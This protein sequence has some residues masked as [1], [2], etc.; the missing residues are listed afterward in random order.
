M[1]VLCVADLSNIEGRKLAWFARE[2]WKLDAFRDFDAGTGP[3]LYNVTAASILG[4]DPW[5]IEKKDRNVFGKVPDLSFG[6]QGGV[7]G[8]Q[9]FARVYG[10]RFADHWSTISR[11]P[12]VDKAEANFDKWGYDQI[13]KLEIDRREWV[14][15]E[16]CKLAWRDRH[17]HT[18]RFWYDLQG[19]AEK[20][21][22]NWGQTFRVGALVQ[23]RC[24]AF[25]GQRWMVLRLPSGRHIT[26]FD[27]ALRDDSIT[28]MGMGNEGESTSRAWVR[29]YTHG[30]KLAGNCCQTSARDILVQAL[31]RI[32]AAGYPVVL[33]VHDEVVTEVDSSMDH[34]RL[35]EV[36][37]ECPDWAAGLPLAAAGFTTTRYR[38]D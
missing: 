16:V 2:Q 29:L 11:L 9:T 27:P 22:R 3:D 14:A 36:L 28:Y 20:A 34:K 26:Y 5:E 21:I 18:T 32:E 1:K 17:P 23:I 38:K 37:S 10:V 35:V 24:V 25:K 13:E 4:G 8:A 33:T 15:S 19:A 12:F 31:P 30:G 7:T 6:Y